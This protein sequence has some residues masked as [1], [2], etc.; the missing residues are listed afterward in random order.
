MAMAYVIHL[1]GPVRLSLFSSCVLQHTYI[2]RLAT[3]NLLRDQPEE[4]R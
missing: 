1:D 2:I 3:N 4:L